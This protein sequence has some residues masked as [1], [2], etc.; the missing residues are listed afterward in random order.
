[1][2]SKQDRGKWMLV[3]FRTLEL[4]FRG[5]PDLHLGLDMPHPRRRCRGWGRFGIPP[6]EDGSQGG[7]DALPTRGL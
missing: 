5:L 7:V 4:Y 3:W 1:M 6:V 2:A